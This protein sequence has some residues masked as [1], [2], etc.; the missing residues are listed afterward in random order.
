MRTAIFLLVISAL[1]SMAGTW[2]PQG[3]ALQD[4][5]AQFG[6]HTAKL[7]W[8][9]G[10]TDVFRAWWFILIMLFLLTSVSCCVA[11]NGP[12]ITRQLC[13]RWNMRKAGYLLVHLGV[14]GIAASGLVTGFVGWRGT[15]NLREG[16][17]SNVALTWQQ[18]QATPHFLPFT[19]TNRAFNIEQYPSG[20]PSRF[21]STLEI[22]NQPHEVEVNKPLRVGSYRF[23]QASFGDGGS[24]ITGSGLDLRHGTLTSFNGKIYEKAGLADGTRIELLEFRPFTVETARGEKPTDIGPSVD[25]LVQPPDAPALQLRAYF[26]HP[27]WIGL[28]DGQKNEGAVIYRIIDTGLTNP[29][30]WPLAARILAGEDYK[31]VM[32]PALSTISNTD[33]RV[34]SG[35]AVMQTTKLIHTLGL[36]HLL[37]PKDYTLKRYSG[38]QVVYDPAADFFWLAALMLLTG[39]IMMVLGTKRSA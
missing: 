22:Q 1:A 21:F 19:V 8:Y 9:A 2:L 14:L 10:L 35:I 33:E 11:K 31:V 24:T 37:L 18:K 27:E 16:E 32:A 12:A 13:R 7:L 26:S 28:A 36:T 23:Y 34:T 20:M 6:V 17:S 15:L 29:G 4:Y 5:V 30:L 39:V 3:L 25:Y 38:L